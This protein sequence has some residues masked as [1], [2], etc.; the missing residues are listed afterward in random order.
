MKKLV[1]CLKGFKRIK[2][3]L[4]FVILN[5]FY[6][7][8]ASAATDDLSNVMTSVQSDFGTGSTFIK[9]MYLLEIIVAVYGYHKSKNIGVLV[10]IVVISIFLNFALGHWVFNA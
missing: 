10:G 7:L 1:N 5:L 8:P 2:L 9:I 4:V 6:T 3:T